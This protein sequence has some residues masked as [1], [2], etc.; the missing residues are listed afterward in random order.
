MQGANL[1]V[2]EA[3]F[4]WRNLPA[5]L[6]CDSRSNDHQTNSLGV[7]GYKPFSLGGNYLRHV[8]GG[9]SAG[10]S[11]ERQREAGMWILPLGG[12]LLIVAL[13]LV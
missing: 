10:I 8:C 1:R 2:V 9:M 7:I 5:P 6:L 11:L 13:F 4:L 3:M 12:H